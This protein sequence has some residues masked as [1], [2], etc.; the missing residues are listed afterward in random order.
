MSTNSDGG[1]STPPEQRLNV[2]AMVFYIPDPLGCFLDDLRRELVHHCNPHAHV[3]VLPPRPLFV[4][5]QTALD[6]IVQ[7]AANWRPFDIELGHVQ[8]FAE[9]DVLFLNIAHDAEQELRRMHQELTVERLAFQEPYPY[10]P[11]VTLAQEIAHDA[12]P[13]LTEVA[14]RRWREYRGPRNFRAERAVFV[15]NCVDNVWIDL[16]EVSLSEGLVGKA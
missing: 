14:R 4:D 7:L 10:H 8:V 11:H 6:E 9:T 12:V 15:Q 1:A 13:A 16:A 5:L 3:T 2:Y